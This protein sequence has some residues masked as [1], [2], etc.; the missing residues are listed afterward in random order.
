MPQEAPMTAAPVAAVAAAER[1]SSP[2]E[3]L[4]QS[5]LERKVEASREEYIT[6]ML[7]LQTLLRHN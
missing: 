2:A 6:R 1:A 5:R 3:R 4:I 7:Y